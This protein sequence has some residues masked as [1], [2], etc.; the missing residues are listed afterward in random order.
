MAKP[1]KLQAEQLSKL[2]VIVI[3]IMKDM[4]IWQNFDLD[5]LYQ[6][7][8][9][10]L[11]RNATQRHGA[12]KWQRGISREQVGL[13]FVEV[14]E[15]HPELLSGD[16]NAYAAFVLHHEFIHALGFLNHV[17]EFRHLEYSWPGVD[18]GVIGPDFTEFLRRKSAKWL[19][20]CV[21]CSKSFPRK[22]PSKGKYR[23]RKCSTTL[24][25]VQT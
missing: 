17:S 5:L 19:W 21:T 3:E 14:I 6:I 13:E 20:K 11:K 15:L 8:L 25:D 1:S 4:A 7:P 18:A 2:R 24:T 9:A 12:T 22:K 16:W 23:C 10:V